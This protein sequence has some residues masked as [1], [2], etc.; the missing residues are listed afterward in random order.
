ML[1]IVQIEEVDPI[2]AQRLEALLERTAGARRVERVGLEIAVELGRHD[3]ALRQAAALANDGADPLFAA[4]EPIIARGVDELGRP[5]ENGVE[6]RP[7]ARLVD[8]IA[9]GVRHVAEAG[10]AKADGRDHDIGAAQANLVH[11]ALSHR[12][13]SLVG[14]RI[15]KAPARRGQGAADPQRSA[16]ANAANSAS[17]G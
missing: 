10:G 8:A 11:D 13:P 3:E 14:R 1:G 9:V 2:E 7:G 15:P 5:I 16:A 6:R 17:V 12:E 4:A